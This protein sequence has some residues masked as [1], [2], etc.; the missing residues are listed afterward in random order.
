MLRRRFIF[1]ALSFLFI[2]ICA[3]G[4]PASTQSL[5]LEKH[6]Q[7]F[8]II[9]PNTLLDT[10]TVTTNLIPD[11]SDDAV[12]VEGAAS[13]T[14]P[15][16]SYLIAGY[17]NG[18]IYP[19][20]RVR[21]YIRFDLSGIPVDGTI[22]SATFRIYHAGGQ[23]YPNTSRDVSFY[24][25]TEV[26]DDATLTW[27]NRP[28][29]AE[30][31]GASSTTYN[32]QGWYE[33]DITQLVR[34]WVSGTTPNYGI[35]AVGP[36][37]ITGV[38][39]SF[40]A[41]EVANG[42]EI[43][44]RYIPAPPPVLDIWPGNIEHEMAVSS[45]AALSFD[46]G[47]VTYDSLH[48]DA[49]EVNGVSWL[50]INTASGDV[51]PPASNKVSLS[52]DTSAL[53][54]GTY[55]EQIRVTSSTP[56]V[57][58]S[59][60]LTT[61][62][63]EVVDSLEKIYLPVILNSNGG[64]STPTEESW[65]VYALSIGVSEYNY[66]DS[67]F[68]GWDD[69]RF[70][71]EWPS[72]LST[73]HLDAIAID[74]VL[75]QHTGHTHSFVQ[76]VAH[77]TLHLRTNSEATLANINADLAAITSAIN[78]LPNGTNSLFVFYFSGHGS[79]VPDGNG[80]E[81]DGWDEVIMFHDVA[82]VAG[83]F[84]GVY[85]DDDLEDKLSNINATQIVLIID[86]CFSGSLASGTTSLQTYGLQSRGVS[87]PHLL[88]RP[89]SITSTDAT[90]AELNGEGRLI[91]TG[92]TGD[93][94][95]YEESNVLKHGVFTYFFLEGLEEALYDANENSRISFEEAYWFSRDAVD[96]WVFDVVG[97]HQNPAIHDHVHGQVD[98]TW[99]P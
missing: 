83:G 22:V 51:T 59:P 91:I 84:T 33:L 79:Q 75:D 61:I 82:P 81:A 76:R 56:E 67:A 85:T 11:V 9:Q 74:N 68:D 4:I 58:G 25:V 17:D 2:F 19:T 96:D 52:V 69:I 40:F 93:Q 49:A 44:V 50:Q 80:D 13:T 70:P 42:P 14:H 46:V 98:V 78:S 53:S 5:N 73:P 95:T 57:E 3:N 54:P 36:E 6:S 39:R 47:T 99:L 23:D 15:S 88:N 55:S 26:W 87:A 66:L 60:M 65:E 30:L 18:S 16:D 38:Y 27:N 31:L 8:T 89:S 20:G 64:E 48:W 35:V 37:S 72:L 90:L 86:S 92:G 63:I 97:E 94:L 43:A 41:S 7:S 34:D 29:Y 10:T 45:T 21:S 62:T 28:A 77:E 1:L 24:R 32:Y 71:D 12:A